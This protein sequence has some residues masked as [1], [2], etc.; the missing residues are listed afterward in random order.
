MRCVVVAVKHHVSHT[1]DRDCIAG[2]QSALAY[3]RVAIDGGAVSAAEV[4][5]PEM[6]ATPFNH[7]VI[8][9]N[10][11][12]INTN[13]IVRRAPYG[14]LAIDSYFA[15]GLTGRAYDQSCL[16]HLASR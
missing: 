13:E 14:G 10:Q 7:R 16:C 5:Q 12:I 3:Y 1:A 11:V 8:L 4:A 15:F 6:I 2:L 9:R